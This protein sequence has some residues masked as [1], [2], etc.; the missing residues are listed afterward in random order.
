MTTYIGK[1][2]LI[3]D[4]DETSIMV[5]QKLLQQSG[6]SVSVVSDSIEAGRQLRQMALP[7]VIFLDLEMPR[8]NGYVVLEVIREIPAMK[9]IPVVAYTTHTSH[10]NEVKRA[11]FNGFLGKPLDSRQFPAQLARILAGEAVWEV[12]G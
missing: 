5:M 12:P 2:A 4:D 1:N 9:A 10:L 3:I 11:G 7:D 8:S 6:M